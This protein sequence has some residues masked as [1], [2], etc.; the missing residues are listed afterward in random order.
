MLETDAETPSLD[1]LVKLAAEYGVSE[2]WLLHGD[3]TGSTAPQRRPQLSP[4]FV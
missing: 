1:L 2:T 4:A 3:S